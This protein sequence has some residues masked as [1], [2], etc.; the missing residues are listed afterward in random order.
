[1]PSGRPSV[2][3]TAQRSVSRSMTVQSS[4]SRS[5]TPV[6]VTGLFVAVIRNYCLQQS[7]HCPNRTSALL[8]PPCHRANTPQRVAPS[9]SRT[10]AASLF[11]NPRRE[12]E[13]SNCGHRISYRGQTAECHIC[14]L[15][16]TT[17]PM[18]VVVNRPARTKFRARYPE[19]AT[20]GEI[21]SDLVRNKIMPKVRG[22]S[23]F[24]PDLAIET[25][26]S[27]PRWQRH[28]GRFHLPCDGRLGGAAG[29]QM[30]P[31]LDCGR[32]A[33]STRCPACSR[34]HARAHDARRVAL[35]KTWSPY[36]DPSYRRYRAWVLAVRPPCC[37]C[38]LPG[39]DTVDHAIPLAYDPT[40][41]GPGDRRIGR[42]TR[43]REA[44]YG[45]REKSLA[46]GD[47][48][49][50]H[51]IAGARKAADSHLEPVNGPRY[52][53][54]RH[55]DH[56]LPQLRQRGIHALSPNRVDRGRPGPPAP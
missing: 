14:M 13:C 4:R 39:S 15:R 5:W 30:R 55:V 43:G 37:Y 25:T 8:W 51:A 44:R 47:D 19:Q 17:S 32:V 26:M 48:T 24:P 2:T 31:C 22:K 46:A 38:R 45:G 18:A 12:L 34:A 21:A 28:A 29:G 54:R 33:P 49:G 36:S 23:A 3:R 9:A 27:D 40:G 6:E 50:Q 42:A 7:G 20:I 11:T 41:T 16:G 35:G 53:R 10:L 52:R 56:P 1:M